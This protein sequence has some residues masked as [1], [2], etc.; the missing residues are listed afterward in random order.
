LQ[1]SGEARFG[2]RRCGLF[3]YSVSGTLSADMARLSSG[4]RR[5]HIGVFA[6]AALSACG[7]SGAELT[8]GA[9]S[10][11][12]ELGGFRLVSVSGSGTP[13]DPIV[14]VEE[15]PEVVPVTLVVRRLNLAADGPGPWQPT[16]TIVK[17][18]TNLS[19]RVW[20]GFEISL[21]ERQGEPSDYG[22]GLSF[23]QF[24][25]KPPDVS[26]D[27]FA[28]NNRVFEPHDRIR[29]Q[30]GHLDPQGTAQFQIT[31]TDP[32]PVREFFLVQDPQLLSVEAPTTNARDF[33]RLE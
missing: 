15:L 25:A 11:S 7:A 16:L 29:F 23:N 10:F 30:S 4:L 24:G 5:S 31:I 3:R 9:F 32:T 27:A 14:I 21:E 6:A 12:D 18:I 20:A 33:A 26:S 17:R 22:D 1:Q 13:T 8:T 2:Q 28:D 19:D